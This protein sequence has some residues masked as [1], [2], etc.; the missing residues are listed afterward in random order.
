MPSLSA[1]V[2]LLTNFSTPQRDPLGWE[3]G[4][5]GIRISF[6]QHGRRYGSTYL[7]DVAREQGWTKEEALISLM[8]KAGWN[9]SS[10][11]WRRVWDN[12]RGELITYEGRQVG[13]SFAEWKAWRDWADENSHR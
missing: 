6:T 5:H 7:P 10:D 4:K 1:H 12:G 11:D 8:Q 3:L 9:G 2:T 13:L